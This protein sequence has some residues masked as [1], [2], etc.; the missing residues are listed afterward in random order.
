[1]IGSELCRFAAVKR[2][3]ALYL[4]LLLRHTKMR[5][6]TIGHHIFPALMPYRIALTFWWFNHQLH[7]RFLHSIA[8]FSLM[9][10]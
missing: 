3:G 6:C 4:D 10:L 7:A 8:F 1:M 9:Y 2:E 5:N